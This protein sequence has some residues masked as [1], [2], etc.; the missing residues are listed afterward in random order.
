MNKPLSIVSLVFDGPTPLDFVG[1]FEI[2]SRLPGAATRIVSPDG[3][4]ISAAGARPRGS[5]SPRLA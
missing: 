5:L 4:E 2:L 1:P 3:G